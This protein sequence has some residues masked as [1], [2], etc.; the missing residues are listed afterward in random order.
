MYQTTYIRAGSLAEA[1][2]LLRD[3]LEAKLISGGLRSVILPKD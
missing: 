1:E 2:N 3:N